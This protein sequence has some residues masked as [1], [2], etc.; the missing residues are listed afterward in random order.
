MLEGRKLAEALAR[1]GVSVTLI[2][3]SAAA[4]MIKRVDF[5]LLGADRIAPEFL[6]NKIGTRMITLAARERG[7]RVYALCDTSKFT[8]AVEMP[9][10]K[11]DSRNKDELWPD[12]PDSVLVLNH[13][14]EPTPLI[15]FTSIITEDGPLQ[16]E[17]ARRRAEA[18]SGLGLL[19]KSE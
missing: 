12:A 7:A 8:C 2:A 10:S 16:P 14:F 19:A 6:V 18:K 9:G 11:A 4:L 5:V 13:Y 17:Q 3:D 1:E 15:Y